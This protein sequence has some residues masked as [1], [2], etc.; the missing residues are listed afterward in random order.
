MDVDGSTTEE[1]TEDE[2]EQAAAV[3]A[4]P[5]VAG[6]SAAVA[7]AAA[8]A[9]AAVAADVEQLVSMGFSSR[10]AREALEEADY[11]IEVACEWLVANCV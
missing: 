3:A 2:A 5:A 10:Q 8:A 9:A 11:N 6:G 7:A 4:A 1:E